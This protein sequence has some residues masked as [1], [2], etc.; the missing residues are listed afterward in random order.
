MQ[1]ILEQT[2]K[3]EINYDLDLDFNTYI[4]KVLFTSE[5][6]RYSISFVWKKLNLLDFRDGYEISVIKPFSM[7]EEIYYLVTQCV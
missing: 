7:L 3:K 5:C 1:F 6:K 2:T 4:K